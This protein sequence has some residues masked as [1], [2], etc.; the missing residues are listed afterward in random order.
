LL[1]WPTPCSDPSQLR[2]PI[3]AVLTNAIQHGSIRLAHSKLLY[4]AREL[5]DLDYEKLL[6]LNIRELKA[7]ARKYWDSADDLIEIRTEALR[8]HEKNPFP[9]SQKLADRTD[10]RIRA[11]LQNGSPEHAKLVR[12]GS[13]KWLIAGSIGLIG[14]VLYGI[15]H[16]VGQ[17]LWAFIRAA[18]PG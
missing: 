9:W 11:L 8:R 3:A 12:R 4:G 5:P 7:L 10:A 17:D 1:G 6:P 15:A 14:A 18:V 2:W 13:W 16:G